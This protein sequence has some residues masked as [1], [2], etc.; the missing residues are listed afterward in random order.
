MKTEEALRQVL[1]LDDAVVIAR[2]PSMLVQWY[3][4]GVSLQIS[5]NVQSRSELG[6]ITALL[7][8]REEV[9]RTSCV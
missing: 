3:R 2:V 9:R 1:N 6:E 7:Y 4:R 8:P 5:E